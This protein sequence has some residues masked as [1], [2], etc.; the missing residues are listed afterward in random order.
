MTVDAIQKLSLVT[1]T[2]G[3][4][5]PLPSVDAQPHI[6]H[7]RVIAGCYWNPKIVKRVVLARTPRH[8]EGYLVIA[9]LAYDLVFVTQA[10]ADAWVMLE[11]DPVGCGHCDAII[12]GNRVLVVIERGG[13][14]S[15]DLNGDPTTPRHTSGP[16][17]GGCSEQQGN[18]LALSGD[19]G[20]LMVCVQGDGW[21]WEYEGVARNPMTSFNPRSISVW[22]R[23]DATGS[24]VTVQDFGNGRSLFLGLA[25]HFLLDVWTPNGHLKGDRVY[26]ADV[27]GSQCIAFNTRNQSLERISFPVARVARQRPM[28]LRPSMCK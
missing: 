5:I 24:W 9:I 22:Q 4:V 18:F 10:G 23:D 11:Y 26:I 14:I 17:L 20:L 12:L 19:G 25:Y 6:E 21:V 1:L 2:S 27:V 16:S 15:W 7:L 3:D 8:Q 28:W 13:L